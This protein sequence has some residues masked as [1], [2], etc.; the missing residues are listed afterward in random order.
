MKREF[1]M[2]IAGAAIAFGSAALAEMAGAHRIVLPRDIKWESAPASLPAGAEAAVLYGDPAKEGMFALRVR[3]PKNYRI[4]PHTHP[5]A[6]VVTVIAGK[7]RL[8]MGPKA[9]IPSAEPIGAGGFVSMPPK[10]AHYVFADEDTILQINAIGPW[11][12]DYLDPKDD[13]RL[14]IAPAEDRASTQRHD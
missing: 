14:N 8:G 12:I 9:D 13:P 10:V 2:I 5:Q 4:A 1:A 7:F 3:I 11:A 6:E